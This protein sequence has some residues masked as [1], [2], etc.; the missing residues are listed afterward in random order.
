MTLG[1][2]YLSSSQFKQQDLLAVFY[3]DFLKYSVSWSIAIGR[4]LWYVA[5][6][7]THCRDNDLARVRHI[8][9]V[10]FFWRHAFCASE[11]DG[12]GYGRR[13]SAS[14]FGLWYVDLGMRTINGYGSNWINDES[15]RNVSF[16]VPNS[17][18]DAVIDD[19]HYCIIPPCRHRFDR[20]LFARVSCSCFCASSCAKSGRTAKQNKTKYS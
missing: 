14:G 19:G 3:A 15:C 17:T 11:Y 13:P 6:N 8:G 7:E 2:K 16:P 5:I 9:A 1:E 12:N 20:C 18:S 4:S 10:L